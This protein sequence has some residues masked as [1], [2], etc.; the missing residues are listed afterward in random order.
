MTGWEEGFPSWNGDG[1]IRK[2]FFIV[3]NMNDPSVQVNFNF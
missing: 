2:I 1:G 3:V